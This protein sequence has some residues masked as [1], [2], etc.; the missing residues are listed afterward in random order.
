MVDFVLYGTGKYKPQSTPVSERVAS[1]RDKVMG[2]FGMRR[3]VQAE[4]QAQPTP[5]APEGGM[6]TTGTEI[7]DIGKA[8]QNEARVTDQAQTAARVQG[9]GLFDKA[10]TEL[11]EENAAQLEEARLLEAQRREAEEAQAAAREQQKLQSAIGAAQAEQDALKTKLAGDETRKQAP[12]TTS[13][14]RPTGGWTP[15]NEGA[16]IS[17]RTSGSWRADTSYLP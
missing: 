12:L 9:E 5:G 10:L 15:R 3:R 17:R 2:A 8:R 13:C 4:A 6:T 7:T 14:A 11:T 1:A 16:G